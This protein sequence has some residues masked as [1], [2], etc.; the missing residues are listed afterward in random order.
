MTPGTPRSVAEWTET[1]ALAVIER[2]A[3]VRG[4]LL[5]VLH[6]IQETFGQI[7][8]QSIRLIAKTLNLSRADVHGVVTFYQDFRTAPAGRTTVQVCRGEACQS[9][10]GTA[11][12]EHAVATVGVGFGDTT[13]DGALTL[14][15]VFCLGNCAL[16][17]AIAVDGRLI[18]RVTAER[19]DS[20][21]MAAKSAS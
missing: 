6:A 16:S 5:P 2:H 11:L 21:I 13:L 15:Q 19:F 1:A 7:D 12:A 17:P 14:D 3:H 8:Q 18:G 4:P 9:M 10:G 20:L